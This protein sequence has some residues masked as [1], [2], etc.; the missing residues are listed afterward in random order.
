MMHQKIGAQMST[1]HKEYHYSVTIQTDDL[2]LLG[3]LRALSQHVQATGNK[4]IPWGGTKR[5]DWLQAKHHATFHFSNTLYR[6]E[7]LQ[8]ARRLLPSDLWHVTEQRNDDP[9]KPQTV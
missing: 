9:A 8:N 7:F 4:R 1:S 2:A 6:D 3:C 5:K